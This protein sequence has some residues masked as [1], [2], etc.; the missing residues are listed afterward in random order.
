MGRQ[1]GEMLLRRLA[2][3]SVERPVVTY[4]AVLKERSSTLR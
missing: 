1:A 2:G 4:P 3:L